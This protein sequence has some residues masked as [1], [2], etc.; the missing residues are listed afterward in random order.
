[1]TSRVGIRRWIGLGALILGIWMLSVLAF[2]GELVF[3]GSLKWR[4]ALDLSIRDWLPWIALGPAVAWLASRF[5]LDRHRL[6]TSLPIHCLGCALAVALCDGLARPLAVVP[7]PPAPA[8]L[9]PSPGAPPVPPPPPA[10]ESFP[11]NPPQA[12]PAQ[13]APIPPRPMEALVRRAKSNLPVY[14]LIVSMAQ[15]AR[16]YRRA[17]AR[18]R[19]ALELQTH[20][21]RAR[22]EALRMQLHPHFL[23]N[24]LNAI[25]ALVHKDPRAADDMIGNLSELLRVALDVSGQEEIP[26]RQELQVLDRYL[27]IQRCRFG[28]RLAVAKAIDPAVL[29]AFVPA[30]ILQPLVEN[31]IRHGLD[32]RPGPGCITI[33][34]RRLESRLRLAVSDNGGG[35]PA[36]S[37]PKEGIGLSNAKARLIELYGAAGRLS[38]SSRA[39]GGCVVE[40]EI[41]F[42]ENS[43]AD[44]R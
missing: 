25:S 26:L 1:M 2:A 6:P 16:L 8:D 44:H 31:A 23:F 34:A 11:E 40:L 13:A 39:D 27:A 24:A 28:E 20:L 33:Q 30:L 3:A 41:P 37:G 32:P 4:E 22:L 17:Q 42:H 10:G 43:S 5:P 35:V 21:V 14:W 29:G 18:E 36:P 15:A 12:P 38:F 7:Q 9:L 19:R